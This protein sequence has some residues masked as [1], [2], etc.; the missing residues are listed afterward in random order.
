MD[1][2]S[3]IVS[4]TL[5]LAKKRLIHA[6]ENQQP[7]QDF[8]TTIEGVFKSVPGPFSTLRTNYL[9]KSY[10]KKNL[11][12]VE[13]EEITIAKPLCRKV[14]KNKRRIINQEDKFA[15]IPLKKSLSQLLSN[16]K[17]AKY[18]IK[19]PDQCDTNIFYDI[20]DGDVFR[21]DIFFCEHPDALQIIL[22][23][24]AVEVCNPIGSRA[25]KQKL[26]MF[27]YTLANFNPKIRSR[28]CATRLL[29]IANAK[30][31]KEYGYH[32]ILQPINQEIKEI[33]LGF[34][35]TINGKR[36]DV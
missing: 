4:N 26:D 2:T 11:N 24:D 10:I 32:A 9:Q 15:Y 34:S 22:Y 19:Y 36:K 23:H 16:K 31:V 30:V 5:A 13:L 25:G 29:A 1:S 14:L 8:S 12:Y 7:G 6:W 18:T 33:E 20:C 17:I 28:H 35:C 3:T 27:Y 21:N